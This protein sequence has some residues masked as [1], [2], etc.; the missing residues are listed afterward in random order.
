MTNL[1]AIFRNSGQYEEAKKFEA[2]IN[3]LN[4]RGVYSHITEELIIHLIYS[5]DW[6]VMQ[7][8]LDRR[9][10]EVA[11]THGIIEAAAK[12]EEKGVMKLLLHRRGDQIQ[13]Q[14]ISSKLQQEMLFMAKIY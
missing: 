14:R 12:S 6:E 3:I 13:L 7:F 2:M 9:S 10:D 8:L 5:F 1:A 4:R 11:I